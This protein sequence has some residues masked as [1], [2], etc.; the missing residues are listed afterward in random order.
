MRSNRKFNE[1]KANL[2]AEYTDAIKKHE[3]S[4][5]VSKKRSSS[6]FSWLSPT[7]KRRRG[8]ENEEDED[9]SP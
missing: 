1:F 5:L 8:D 2:D 4:K 7:N 9:D 3:E 6:I